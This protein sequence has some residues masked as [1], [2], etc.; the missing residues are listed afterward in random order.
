MTF[1]RH[2]ERRG[3]VYF[4]GMNLFLLRHGLAVERKEFYFANDEFRPLTPKG[5]RQLRKVAAALRAMELR[6]DVIL[7]SPLVRARQT[8]EMVAADVKA[9]KRLAFADELKPGGNPKKLIQKIAAQKINSGD[10]LLV[11]HEPDLSN[12]I[13]LLVTGSRDAGFTLKKAGV[14]KLEVE[15]LCAGKC[16]ALA[17]LL[18]PAQMKLMR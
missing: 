17:W 15:K 5:K 2:C 16:A 10:V 6:F 9:R 3:A 13:S 4:V 14:A 18:T 1:R 8:A 7:S 12:L 11:G